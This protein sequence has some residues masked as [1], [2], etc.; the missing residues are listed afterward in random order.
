MKNDFDK[1]KSAFS[2]FLGRLSKGFVALFESGNKKEFQKL[3]DFIS[4]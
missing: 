3:K 4:S 2:R 1:K